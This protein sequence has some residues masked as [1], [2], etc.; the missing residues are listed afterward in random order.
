M[1]TST[2]SDTERLNR[3]LAEL[4]ERADA[5]VEEGRWRCNQAMEVLIAY[6]GWEEGWIK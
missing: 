3:L 5:L 2:P 4:N 6:Q 1:T